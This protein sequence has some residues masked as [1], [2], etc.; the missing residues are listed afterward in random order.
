MCDQLVADFETCIYALRCTSQ[1]L[2]SQ[3]IS[4]FEGRIQLLYLLLKTETGSGCYY[5]YQ[6]FWHKN[7]ASGSFSIV[8]THQPRLHTALKKR[9]VYCWLNCNISYCVD[10]G[11]ASLSGWWDWLSRFQAV[12]IE[13]VGL[14]A[15]NLRHLERSHQSINHAL[16]VSQICF[17]LS[18]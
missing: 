10:E 3:M 18:F 14:W 1:P 6:R 12:E 15:P 5:S 4:H 8:L 16:R 2:W 13:V 11:G 7:E 9:S 17:T